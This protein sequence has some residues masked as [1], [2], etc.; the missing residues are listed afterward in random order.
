MLFVWIFSVI[1]SIGNIFAQ[2]KE[3]D[4]L[5]LCL[6][7]ANADTNKVNIFLQL[8]DNYFNRNDYK[9][10]FQYSDLALH[11]AIE[12]SFITGV[13]K[14][15]MQLGNCYAYQNNLTEAAKNFSASGAAAMAARSRSTHC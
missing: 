4:S 5:K 3:I 2:T 10:S 8:S 14:A 11:T 1:F 13:F 9:N 12:L 15:Y 6:G 7:K